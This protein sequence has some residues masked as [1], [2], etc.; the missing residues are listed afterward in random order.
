M[1][2]L[3]FAVGAAL[4]SSRQVPATLAASLPHAPAPLASVVVADIDRDGDADV[5]ATDGAL[6]L[7]VWIND[8]TGRYTQQEP[9]TGARCAGAERPN[10]GGDA[11]L[12]DP[13]AASDPPTIDAPA[14]VHAEALM[15]SGAVARRSADGHRSSPQTARAL[16]GPPVDSPRV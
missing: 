4:A 7:F 15:A 5:V 10:V 13:L 11:P 2:Q 3:L 1:M 9:A 14:V 12:A 16:R 8:G 6:H